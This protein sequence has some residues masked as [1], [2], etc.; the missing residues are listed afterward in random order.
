MRGKHVG[1]ALMRQ[2]RMNLHALQVEK[3]E[4]LVDWD[5]MDLV[6]FL[7]AQGFQP[8]PRLCLRLEL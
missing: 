3:I 5:R 8:A 4:T 2:L 6:R 1:Q 7:G